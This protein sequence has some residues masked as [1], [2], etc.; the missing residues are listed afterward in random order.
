MARS[1]LLSALKPARVSRH[2]DSH[3]RTGRHHG[4]D[5]RRAKGGRTQTRTR[6]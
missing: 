5:D 4:G 1:T 3:T 6:G 2:G